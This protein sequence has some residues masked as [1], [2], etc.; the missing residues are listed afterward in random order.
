MIRILLNHIC[1]QLFLW[2][3]VKKREDF[4]GMSWITAIISIIIRTR[5]KMV[6]ILI[7]VRRCFVMSPCYTSG[8]LLVLLL[9]CQVMSCHLTL[10]LVII[11]WTGNSN[12]R[13]NGQSMMIKSDSIVVW[14][15]SGLKESTVKKMRRNTW[16]YVAHNHKDHPDLILCKWK[17]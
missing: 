14:R 13:R 11:D 8:C 4:S 15:K 5:N 12:L 3:G 7:L 16:K 2:K 1:S 9:F 6:L 10:R 17:S